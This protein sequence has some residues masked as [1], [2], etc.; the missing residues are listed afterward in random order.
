MLRTITVLA[1]AAALLAGCSSSGSSTGT[2]TD[3]VV[4]SAT[5][6]A[7]AVPTPSLSVGEP[8]SSGQTGEP[9]QGGQPV[10]A[11]DGRRFFA[12]FPGAAETAPAFDPAIVTDLD[13]ALAAQ[14]ADPTSRAIFDTVPAA[15][16]AGVVVQV[17]LF[18]PLGP[19]AEVCAVTADDYAG[20]VD[21]CDQG[22][23]VR[24]Q[25]LVEQGARWAAAGI[26]L[27]RFTAV[28]A[29]AVAKDAEQRF[30]AAGLVPTPDAELARIAADWARYRAGQAA[31]G[32]F[33]AVD[34]PEEIALG[35]R[36]R[37]VP[38]TGG[39]SKAACGAENN[40]IPTVGGSSVQGLVEVV[41]PGAGL[42]L[43]TG[44]AVGHGRLILVWCFQKQ[45]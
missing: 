23:G 44:A 37:A 14:A 43:G 19:G 12:G 5:G 33:T 9:G 25:R 10:T 3:G 35:T 18:C 16:P 13:R 28:Q 22:G 7:T 2:V 29:A 11:A 41:G 39:R 30:S 40:P 4:G 31:P 8:G 15:R 45:P 6:G 32:E 21:G 34:T 27:L 20:F 36:L 1:A 42:R 17:Y 26:C 38:T 24:L